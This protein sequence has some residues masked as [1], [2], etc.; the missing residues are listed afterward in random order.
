MPVPNCDR[1]TPICAPRCGTP[2]RSIL[3]PSWSGRAPRNEH[4]RSPPGRRDDHRLVM[5]VFETG[6][7]EEGEPLAVAQAVAVDLA[8]PKPF[9]QASKRSALAVALRTGVP[10][11][12]RPLEK[13]Q[14]IGGA[15]VGQID[16]VNGDPARRHRPGAVPGPCPQDRR[17]VRA[18]R[19]SRR[20]QTQHPR[21]AA[22]RTAPAPG[23]RSAEASL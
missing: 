17:C 18:P 23:S 1:L 14:R 19:R 15:M 22:K 6:A 12:V 3:P 11:L 20:R 16:L 21:T 9:E 2:G 5:E 13:P 4:G 10:F 8:A 7:V